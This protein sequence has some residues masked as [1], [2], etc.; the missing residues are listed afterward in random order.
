MGTK[1][2]FRKHLVRAS[3]EMACLALDAV[4]AEERADVASAAVRAG[5]AMEFALRAVVATVSPAL[6]FVPRGLKPT[7]PA[8]MVHAHRTATVSVEWLS[9][10]T[11]T[12][13]SL[14]RGLAAATVGGLTDYNDDIERVVKR[15]D[16]VVHMYAVE[17]DGLR[18]SLT[19]LARVIGVLL[20]HLKVTGEKFWGS[21]RLAF[22]SE[23]ID[24]RAGAVRADVAVKVREAQLRVEAASSGILRADARHLMSVLEDQ[25]SVFFPPG[26]LEVFREDC[27]ACGFQAEVLVKTE[28][29]IDN[30]DD[31]ELVDWENDVPTAVLIPQAPLSARLQCPV[32]RLALGYVELQ[33]TQPGLAD[34]MRYELAPRRG[35]MQE[36]DEILWPYQDQP[37]R[38]PH[39]P[40]V[41]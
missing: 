16:A 26:P 4:A 15:R 35:T 13:M 28:D 25:G 2:A 27:P 9:A 29:D 10:Q 6:L 40:H 21:G 1:K 7:T 33:E 8:A 24:E 12:D 17:T 5:M 3:S 19:S 11:S 23:L 34:L 36:Y 39:G 32:C 14:V 31:L 22:V 18:E 38:I 37:G 41:G 30:P 20:P